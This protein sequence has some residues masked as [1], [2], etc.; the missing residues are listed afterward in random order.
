MEMTCACWNIPDSFSTSSLHCESPQ[1][2]FTRMSCCGGQ[3][4]NAFITISMIFCVSISGG[5]RCFGTHYLS[6]QRCNYLTTALF[7]DVMECVF[8]IKW[9]Y[10]TQVCFTSKANGGAVLVLT[11][12][13]RS[14]RDFQPTPPSLLCLSHATPDERSSCTNFI[15]LHIVRTYVGDLTEAEQSE[16]RNKALR[17]D[18]FSFVGLLLSSQGLHVFASPYQSLWEW[19]FLCEV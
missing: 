8:P 13:W 1:S 2:A 14:F 7:K 19:E 10:F 16:G 18:L 9:D 11:S 5:W 4:P 3:L 6:A 12:R 17:L 15:P